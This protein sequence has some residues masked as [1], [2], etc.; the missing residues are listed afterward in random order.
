MLDRSEFTWVRT[1]CARELSI[2]GRPAGFAFIVD[3]LERDRRYR[4]EMLRFVREQF[5]G[6]RQADDAAVLSFV[7]ARAK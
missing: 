3:A 2:A 6:L 4:Q 5:P 1:N 7:R